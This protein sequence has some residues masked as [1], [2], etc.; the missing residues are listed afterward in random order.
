MG[1]RGEKVESISEL[2]E[3]FK[4]AKAASRTYLISIKVQQH[5]WTPGDAW[6]DV[7][8]PEVS[9]RKEV[10]LAHADHSEGQKKQRIGV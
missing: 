6:W 3:A 1:A 5:Q 4:R 7:G 9:Q 10:R 2:E 8:V